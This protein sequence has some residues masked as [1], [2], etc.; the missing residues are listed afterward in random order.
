MEPMSELEN[1]LPHLHTYIHTYTRSHL[2]QQKTLGFGNTF[3]SGENINN[4]CLCHWVFKITFS[5]KKK[6][7]LLLPSL[8]PRNSNLRPK[9]LATQSREFKLS[10][11]CSSATR[12]NP[13][14][15][16]DTNRSLPRCATA[17][18][19]VGNAYAYKFAPLENWNLRNLKFWVSILLLGGLGKIVS[20]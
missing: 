16:T 1:R 7:F 15:R 14:C 8:P 10:C 3:F 18:S 6:P 9:S 20:L 11:S 19:R 4:V 17:F 12:M 13:P 5:K 2:R